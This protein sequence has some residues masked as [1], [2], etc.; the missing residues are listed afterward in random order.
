MRETSTFGIRKTLAERRKLRREF[1]SVK[2]EYGLVTVKL[3]RL[4]GKVVQAAP[5]FES[6]RK[7]AEQ[8]KASLKQVYEAALKAYQ[9]VP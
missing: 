1:V 3:G 2:T 5:E 6:C 7:V 8:G 9:P 4:D